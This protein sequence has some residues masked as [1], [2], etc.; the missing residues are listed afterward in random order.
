MPP[1][2]FDIE[3]PWPCGLPRAAV[4]PCRL[5]AGAPPPSDA[6]FSSTFWSTGESGDRTILCA[7]ALLRDG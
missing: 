7:L 2:L 6:E 1:W 3:P 4:R 5:R